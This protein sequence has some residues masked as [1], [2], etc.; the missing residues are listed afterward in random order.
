MII[1]LLFTSYVFKK[2]KIKYN[3]LLSFFW[4]G[5][6]LSFGLLSIFSS[7]RIWSIHFSL[8]LIMSLFWLIAQILFA[9]YIN[10]KH[11]KIFT[12]ILVFLQFT[13]FYFTLMTKNINT[14]SEIILSLIALIWI[15][16][17]IML[18]EK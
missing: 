13:T 15:I 2:Y 16:Q 18:K 5:S 17:L 12:Y 6:L 1:D 9:I 10:Y 14:I 11:F 3:S 4:I 7:D 8:A